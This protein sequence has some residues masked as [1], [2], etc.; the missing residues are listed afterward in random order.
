MTPRKP[1]N[2]LC[3]I[4]SSVYGVEFVNNLTEFANKKDMVCKKLLGEGGMGKAYKFDVKSSRVVKVSI[5]QKQNPKKAEEVI[6]TQRKIADIFKDS[7][8]DNGVM[9]HYTIYHDY[10][11][12]SGKLTEY[13]ITNF[14]DGKD[15]FDYFAVPVSI[16]KVFD[17]M[18]QYIVAVAYIHKKGVIHYDLKPENVMMNKK[19]KLFVIDF[20][21]GEVM[22]KKTKTVNKPKGYTPGYQPPVP[23]RYEDSGSMPSRL[24]RYFDYYALARSFF[25]TQGR[26]KFM[27]KGRIPKKKQSILL[28]IRQYF[29]MIDEDNFDDVIS[30]VLGLVSSV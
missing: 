14:I 17:I 9:C 3:D 24:G 8:E 12:K 27:L 4:S 5:D 26:T 22:D 18:K 1:K 30:R 21:F 23:S 25:D 16:N 15:L 13:L 28:D 19:G 20:G 7:C 10:G 29:L 6:N 11:E 2:I